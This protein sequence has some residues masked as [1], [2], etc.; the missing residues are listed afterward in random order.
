[1]EKTIMVSIPEHEKLKKVAERSQE[2]GA[3]VEWCFEKKLLRSTVRFNIHRALAEYFDIDEGKLEA[4]KVA[5][6]ESIRGGRA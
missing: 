1:M 2:C 3:F 6:L 4:E 5:M